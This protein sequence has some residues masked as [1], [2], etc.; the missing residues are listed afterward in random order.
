MRAI[1]EGIIES[2]LFGH[3]KGAFDGAI[4]ERKG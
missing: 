4:E 1:P 2:E 3:Q